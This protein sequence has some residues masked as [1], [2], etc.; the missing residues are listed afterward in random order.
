MVMARPA[1]QRS[2]SANKLCLVSCP[3]PRPSTAR[4]RREVPIAASQTTL[5]T[6]PQF[7]RSAGFRRVGR[8]WVVGRKGVGRTTARPSASFATRANVVGHGARVWARSIPASHR[9]SPLD[10]LDMLDVACPL[11]ATCTASPCSWGAQRPSCPTCPQIGWMVTPN[12]CQLPLCFLS[13]QPRLRRMAA[14]DFGS[15]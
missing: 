12:Q 15:S 3:F 11:I 9:P 6:Y 14:V 7:A 4:E 13:T 2:D 8:R 10:I 5:P 1:D